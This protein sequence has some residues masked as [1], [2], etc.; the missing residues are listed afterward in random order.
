MHEFLV[1]GE[2]GNILAP[3]E[4]DVGYDLVAADEPHIEGVRGMDGTWR[5]VRYIQYRTGVFIQ[6]KPSC[7]PSTFGGMYEV[8]YFSLIYPRSSISKTNLVL[9]NSVGVIDT[10]YRGELLVR[11]KYYWQP[12]DL[13]PEKGMVDFTKIYQKGDKIAQLVFAR[14][15]TPAIRVVEKEELEKTIRHDGGFGSTGS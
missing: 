5:S 15:Y 10:G 6:P 13:W 14:S 11:F 2:D 9:A 8:E 4:G 12:A 7:A 1:A 3:R